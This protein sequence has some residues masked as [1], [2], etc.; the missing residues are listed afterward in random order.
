MK[1]LAALRCTY[2]MHVADSRA[3]FAISDHQLLSD[4]FRIWR[5]C[6]T[7]SLRKQQCTA[8]NIHRFELIQAG[9]TLS[10]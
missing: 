5:T 8:R 10:T 4:K 6:S 1:L 3:S 9:V 7:A 2:V